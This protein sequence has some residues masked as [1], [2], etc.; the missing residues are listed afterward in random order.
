M[1]VPP[2]K[3]FSSASFSVWIVCPKNPSGVVS[4]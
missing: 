4:P 1:R 3:S 2:W